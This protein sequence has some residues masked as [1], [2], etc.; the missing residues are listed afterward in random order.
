MRIARDPG[1]SIEVDWAGDSIT[2]ADPLTGELVD[3]W[4]FVAAL[5]Y[6]AYSYVEAFVDMTLP[7][8]IDAH[9]HTFEAFEA[10]AR[11]LVPDNLRTG[12]SRSDRYEPALNPAYA[13]LGE[14]YGTAIIPARVR[15]T[16]GQAGRRGQRPVRCEPDRRDTAQPPVRRVGRAQRGDRR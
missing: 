16:A 7:S 4:L 9:V 11:L 10:V 15:K 5:S 13:R 6:S 12:V 2:F 8:W 14:H 1:E 3:A